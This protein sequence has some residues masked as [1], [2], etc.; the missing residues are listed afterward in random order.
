MEKVKDES[1]KFAARCRLKRKERDDLS[2]D[3]KVIHL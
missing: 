1:V 3:L 2:A